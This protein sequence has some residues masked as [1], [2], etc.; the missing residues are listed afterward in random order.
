M[1]VIKRKVLLITLSIFLFGAWSPMLQEA[2]RLSGSDDMEQRREG[3]LLAERL[4]QEGDIDAMAYYAFC[5]D[6]GKG[7]AEDPVKAF[8]YFRKAADKGNADAMYMVGTTYYIGLV[9]PR[10]EQLA[11][12][13]LTKS[14]EAGSP[15]AQMSL[16]KKYDHGDIVPRDPIRALALYREA[17]NS[18]YPEARQI[19][20]DHLI[21]GD[22]GEKDADFAIK[23]LESLAHQNTYPNVA[24][25]AMGSLA[26][27][28]FYEGQAKKI[29]IYKVISLLTVLAEKGDDKAISEL[30]DIYLHSSFVFDAG[31]RAKTKYWL[32]RLGENLSDGNYM[33][34]GMSVMSDEQIEP[35]EQL[36]Q[37]R[38]WL[39]RISDPV[40]ASMTTFGMA[41]ECIRGDRPCRI[42]VG[43]A[44]LM[45]ASRIRNKFAQQLQGDLI[46]L[47][48]SALGS[49]LQAIHWYRQAGPHLPRSWRM[50]ER[51]GRGQVEEAFAL[52]P[53]E[54]YGLSKEE[55][56]SLSLLP[57]REE[58]L[59]RAGAGDGLA[60][61]Q[62]AILEMGSDGEVTEASKGWLTRAAEA[63]QV[64]GQIL[65]AMELEPNDA[66]AALGWLRR[67]AQAGSTFGCY[68]LANHLLNHSS[69]NP[70]A[71][72]EA[73][74][75]LT[76]L[77]EAGSEP[78][79]MRL[80]KMP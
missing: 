3:A 48:H 40:F 9:I 26:S 71:V 69:G 65:L 55:E 38:Y 75:L 21:K 78:A 2:M 8:E 34:M 79:K 57:E 51:F 19:L 33:A 77:A 53:V 66:P 35:G 36:R 41:S 1:G 13:W 16:A 30:I 12:H 63:G 76:T 29:D 73:R 5:L 6:T 14:A 58:L 50:A 43:Y 42:D 46:L 23:E 74:T 44:L 15:L 28:Y 25:L 4:A 60:M 11:I 17:A 22:L 56:Q 24:R 80:E 45:D 67:A 47:G 61:V 31:N 20:A 27:A 62:L 52:L 68:R 49:G 70:E 64:A 54:V 59:K 32:A 10:D 18:G 72:A 37:V 7:V 39:G